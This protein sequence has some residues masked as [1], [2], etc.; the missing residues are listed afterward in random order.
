MSH[1]LLI[2]RFHTSDAY[3]QETN[4]HLINIWQKGERSEHKVCLKK[5]PQVPPGGRHSQMA[6][7]WTTHRITHA[8]ALL[9]TKGSDCVP[10]LPSPLL[11]LVIHEKVTRSFYPYKAPPW[12]QGRGEAGMETA[13]TRG[14]RQHLQWAQGQPPK[15]HWFGRP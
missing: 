15:K 1:S 5:N 12:K 8:G 6:H 4:K 2:L 14:S 11:G 10:L 13:K 3:W 9:R 7:L